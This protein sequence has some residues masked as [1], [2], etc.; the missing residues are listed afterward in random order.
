MA[1]RSSGACKKFSIGLASMMWVFKIFSN[2]KAFKRT[3][4]RVRTTLTDKT[5][6][7]ILICMAS[8]AILKPKITLFDTKT[9]KMCQEVK[10]VL[11]K[12]VL[13]L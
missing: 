4:S 12:G 6:P 2:I 1:S 5:A 11:S 9:P 10:K 7:G 8:E 13:R 3:Y